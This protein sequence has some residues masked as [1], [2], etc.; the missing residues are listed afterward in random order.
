MSRKKNHDL[1]KLDADAFYQWV[2][3]C[4]KSGRRTPII[5]D[6]MER[7]VERQC[8]GKLLVDKVVLDGLK[9]SK[10]ESSS[11]LRDFLQ[12]FL[13]CR[14][15]RDVVFLQ[16]LMQRIVTD[17][18]NHSVPFE[19]QSAFEFAQYILEQSQVFPAE[20][21]KENGFDGQ[22]YCQM[23]NETLIKFLKRNCGYRTGKS[24]PLL[25]NIDGYPHLPDVHG[26][27]G[28]VYYVTKV[29]ST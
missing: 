2:V 10:G 18:K 7:I 5:K 16:F 22:K 26:R 15:S 19:N 8:S 24:R 13:E 9:Q 6:M 27:A 14:D 11:E 3:E 12:F 4:A 29:L 21:F 1:S 17:Q 25:R 23:D 28:Y 20:I